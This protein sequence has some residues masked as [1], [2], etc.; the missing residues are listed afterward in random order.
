MLV[1]SKFI[2][3]Q[4]VYLHCDWESCICDSL[5]A[6][7]SIPGC[8]FLLFDSVASITQITFLQS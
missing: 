2:S 8:I 6:E 1:S 4:S 7:K 5:W 3:T